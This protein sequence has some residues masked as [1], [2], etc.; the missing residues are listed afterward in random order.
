[1]SCLFSD[2]SHVAQAYAELQT[3]VRKDLE[4]LTLAPFSSVV[5]GVHIVPLYEGLGSDPRT[6]HMPDAHSAD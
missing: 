2:E 5:T 6:G 3:Q 4:A 1:M